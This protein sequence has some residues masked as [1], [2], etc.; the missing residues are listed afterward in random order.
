MNETRYYIEA[1][2]RGLRILEV[3]SETTPSLNLTDIASAT[4]LSKSTAFRFTYTLEKLGYLKRDPETKH[5]RP[6]L[7]VLRLG[8]TALNSLE[9]SQ[10]ARPYLEIL[11]KLC[12]ETTNMTIRDGV[13]IIYVARNKTQQIV[14]VDLHLGSRLPVHCTSMGKVQLIDIPREKLK[15]L[16]G[17]KPFQKKAPNTITTFDELV[18]ELNQVR[19]QG[20]ATNDEELVAG[21]RSVAA[22]I[23]DHNNEIVA[24]INISIPV[25][26]SSRQKMDTVLAP[27]V[28]DTAHKISIALGS[29]I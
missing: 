29:D 25:A 11:S 22:P 4:Q 21:L 8:F 3:F 27:M 12:G 7:K 1:L 26:R 24:A 15:V 23:R 16:L 10:V 14:S 5:Y 9:V 20:Y 2:D 18:S 17:D 28:M 6:G 13:E 19:Q